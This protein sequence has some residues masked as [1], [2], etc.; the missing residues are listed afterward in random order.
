[1]KNN[2]LNTT[3]GLCLMGLF[4]LSACEEAAIP[5]SADDTPIS[6]DTISFPVVKAI[7]YQ[8]PPEMGKTEY[9]Y[10]GKQDGYDFQYNLI[11]F[12]SSSVTANT[13]FSFYNDSLVIVDSLKLSLR[14]EK[15][16]II[17]N[18][19][20][21]LRY[22]PNGG[23]SVFSDLE[24][25]YLNFDQGIASDIISTAQMETDSIDTNKTEVYLNFMLDSSIVNAFRDTSVL[26]F[27]RSFLVELENESAES[28]NFHSTDI[29][30]GTKP[31]L[32][33]F[34]R[35]FLSDTVVMDTTSRSY[36]SV[37]DITIMSPAPISNEDTAMLSVSMAKGLKSIVFVDMDGW[38]LPSKSIVSSAELIF[39]RVETDSIAPFKVIS[40]PMTSDGIYDQFTSFTNDPYDEDLN[41]FTSTNIVNNV[42]KINHRK[43]A[44]E[45]G[46][47]KF[48]NFG[49]KLQSSFNNDPFTTVQFYGLNNQDYYPVMRVI[50]VLP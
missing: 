8:S 35:V 50:Y 5:V 46:Q 45:I 12:D 47:K 2:I 25:N 20:F 32:T 42:L 27:N 28:F 19:G 21:Q 29:Q 6:L 17:N 48:T 26:D 41:F 11:K 33:V 44:S 4:V 13:P 24:S 38:T 7:A 36:L 16:S 30:A 9:L 40:H 49:F 18:V 22:F 31:E 34:Y 37:A 14:F 43:V 15:D 23:D 3:I 10:F 1:M 39:N